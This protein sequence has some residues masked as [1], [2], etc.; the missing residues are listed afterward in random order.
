M[1]PIVMITI[2]FG[3]AVALSVGSSD[4]QELNSIRA[5]HVEVTGSGQAILL[6]PGLSSSGDVWEGRSST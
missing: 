6:I 4:T 2:G 5:F 1:K 3:I